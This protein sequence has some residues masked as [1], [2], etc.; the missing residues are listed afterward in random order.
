[1]KGRT[2]DALY[3]EWQSLFFDP[4]NVDIAEF[5]TDVMNIACQLYYLDAAQVMVIKGMLVIKIYNTC[6]NIN[7]MNDLKEFLIK[8][9]DNPR[10][11]NSYAAAKDGE[12]SGTAFS[13]VRNVDTPSVGGPAEIGELI[14]KIDSL[15]LSLHALNNKGPIN[16]EFPPVD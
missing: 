2:Q 1:M 5:I 15:E 6:L 16:P 14:S 13:M 7:A 11:K 9:F 12:Y 8:V 10:I 3:A 4:V